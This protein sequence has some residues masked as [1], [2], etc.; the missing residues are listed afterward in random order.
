MVISKKK[1]YIPLTHIFLSSKH[2]EIYN[3]V[4]NQLVSIIKKNTNL[5]TF[6][7]MIS[8]TDFE[9]SLLKSIKKILIFDF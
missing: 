5:K 7:D 8:M 2:E 4:F 3:I 6:N 1:I 9:K